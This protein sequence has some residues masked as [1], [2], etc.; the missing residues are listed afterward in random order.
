MP[1]ILRPVRPLEGEDNFSN[2]DLNVL[3]G[4][5]I[6][7]NNAV[8]DAES[9]LTEG[10]APSRVV[11]LKLL[12]ELQNAIDELID[13]SI[14]AES[15]RYNSTPL[16]SLTNILK[17]K[18]GRFRQSLLGRRVDYSGRSVIAP[19]PHLRL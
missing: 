5:V 13:T 6:N 8:L 3:Y 18:E 17:G 11:Y 1:A 15:L 9:S 19:G 16:K 12:K 10:K 7:A 14:T 2:S 4:K